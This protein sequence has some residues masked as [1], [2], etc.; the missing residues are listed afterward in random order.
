[1]SD[2]STPA[3]RRLAETLVKAAGLDLPIGRIRLL[4]GGW[5][6]KNWRLDLD[7]GDACVLRQYQWPHDS[8]DLDRLE[9]EI[10][11]HALLDRAGVPVP[12]VLASHQ[13]GD[14]SALLME[15]LPG[16]L[17]GDAAQTL[18]TDDSDAAWRSCGAALKKAHSIQFRPGE[19]GVLVGKDLPKPPHPSWAHWRL[20]DLLH[21]AQAV[22]EQQKLA[23]S[24]AD[25][26][27]VLTNALPRLNDFRPCL[28]HNDAHAWNAL[29]KKT[30]D[31]WR[32]SGW[33]DWE[34]AWVG[35]PDW[36]LARTDTWRIKDI[37]PTP[38]AFW[39]GYGKKPDQPRF[40]FYVMSLYLWQANEQLSK[41]D[42]DPSPL[43]RA[44]LQYVD[45]FD[46]YFERLRQLLAA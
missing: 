24:P 22:H 19:Y 41:P 7:S 20:E 11:L 43:H 28:L 40:A 5:T 23:V 13:A 3:I 21:H 1:M 38:E 31:G 32:C 35:D 10:H 33:L 18:P 17:L 2:N 44:A 30:P 12:K 42:P 4:S 9:K 14:A 36:D 29:V 26:R 46:V 6:N 15:Y 8:P 27:A 45:R 25:L 37:G 34:Y 39:H 16:D